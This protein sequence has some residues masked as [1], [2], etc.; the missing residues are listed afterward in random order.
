M[1]SQFDI[2]VVIPVGPDTAVHYVKD[3]IDSYRFYSTTSFKII[4]S[5]DSHQDIGEVLKG[6]YPEAY[7]IKTA[8]PMGGWAGLYL[9][10]ATS[11]RHAVINYE[12]KALLKLD[13]DALVIARGADEEALELFDTHPRIGMAGQYP[14]DYD[15]KPWD[16]GWPRDR[17]LNG[18]TTWK[19]FRRPLANWH[20]RKLYSKARDHNYRA[21][22]S[23]FGGAYFMSYS[24]L[25]KL[26]E[27]GLLPNKMLGRLNLGEDHIFSLLV[28]SIGYHLGSLS[29][30]EKG[31]ALG[32]KGLP[33]SPE[34]L[35]NEGKKIIHST[36][37][38]NG[39]NEESIRNY[40]RRH[41]E[42]DLA[43]L[44]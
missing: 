40:F 6:I 21:G 29:S 37:C 3:T 36:R 28:K 13:T 33:A 19:Y 15:G 1:K 38:W 22:E 39:M 35:R 9:N 5:D 23:V 25:A 16:T 26:L 44:L 27:E 7:V 10:E 2:I 11:F 8:K 18:A 24:C 32:W 12:F 17:I 20:L 34:T 30:R 42:S 43:S 31:F 14:N 4:I 41:R